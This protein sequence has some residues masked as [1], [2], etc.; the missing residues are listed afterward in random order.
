MLVIPAIDLIDGKCVRLTE[1]DFEQKR[2]YDKNPLDTA[3]LYKE[4]GAKR[5][6][7][8]DLDGAKT[9]N[10]INR[11]VIKEIKIKTGLEV[12]TGGGI[13]TENDIKELIDA[14]IDYL[15]FGTLLVENYPLVEMSVKKYGNRFIAGVDV[16]ENKL[17]TRG[18][19]EGDETDIFSLGNRLK[20][21]GIKTSI[22]TDISK[23]GKLKGPNT[24]DTIGFADKTGL[25]V[26]V[27]GGVKDIGDIE[28]IYSKKHRLIE[29]VIVGKA[30][31]EGRIDLENAIKLYQ[32]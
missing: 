23:D 9:G 29:G 8:I 6:H 5:I 13:R 30:Y 16:R 18:W 7:I 11:K 12:E 25:N 26:I 10:S 4:F 3:L 20:E 17:Q 15:I 1:G 2:V 21:I 31:Y 24:D 28:F 19:L 27:S 14:G 22:F 32:S